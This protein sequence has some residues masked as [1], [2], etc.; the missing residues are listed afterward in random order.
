M[1]VFVVACHMAW[2][3]LSGF[4]NNVVML[5]LYIYIYIMWFH[6]DHF[7]LKLWVA[8][9]NHSYH[10]IIENDLVVFSYKFPY[11]NMFCKLFIIMKFAF[12]PP[13]LIM[14]GEITLYHLKL[15]PKLHFAP[16][17]FRMQVLHHKL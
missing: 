4:W 17:T 11:Y 13:P 2:V 5:T 16:K 3:G 6:G 1:S 10:V 14:L 15:Y 12:P 8:L 7:N 9:F